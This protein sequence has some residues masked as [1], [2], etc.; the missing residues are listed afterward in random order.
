MIM[1]LKRFIKICKIKIRSNNVSFKSG[2]NIHK[3]SSFEGQ[4]KI[5]KN[6]WF[7]GDIGYGSYIGDDCIL[8]AKIG[9]FCSIGHKVSV[10]T[11]SHPTNRF[12]STSPMFFSLELQNGATFVN[13]QKFKEKNFADE[14]NK[15]G[16]V[17]GNDVWIGYGVTIMG[18]V[19]I[20]DGAIIG[21][22]AIVMNDV[23]PYTIVVGQ[24]AKKI[25]NRFND[26]Q[27]EWLMKFKWWDKPI[28][29]IREN[30]DLF[31]NIEEFMNLEENL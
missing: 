28:E 15:Y 13:K 16:V 14:K 18:G 20:G 4:N 26:N 17:I 11:G 23:L 2:A 10:I 22:G 9:R 24:P 5:G 21:T 29:W 3:N 19:K 27:I 25:K 12:V 8:K 1:K 31:E 7:E 6:S 30:A